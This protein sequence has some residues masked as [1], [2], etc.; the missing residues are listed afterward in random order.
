MGI[1]HYDDFEVNDRLSAGNASVPVHERSSKSIKR[2]NVTRSQSPVARKRRFERGFEAGTAHYFTGSEAMTSPIS[3]PQKRNIAGKAQPGRTIN[4]TSNRASVSQ[5]SQSGPLPK[6]PQYGQR[7]DQ[8]WPAGRFPPTCPKSMRSAGTSSASKC[9]SGLKNSIKAPYSNLGGSTAQAWSQA[10]GDPA[11]QNSKTTDSDGTTANSSALLPTSSTVSNSEFKRS[12]S[13]RKP[14]NGDEHL[15]WVP[16]LDC[17][18]RDHPWG[19]KS[20][21]A[22][23]EI[24]Q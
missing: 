11:C 20:E 23:E 8:G 16:C 18:D 2:A 21:G 7:T 24:V 10:N 5:E 15:P 4:N 13:C 19:C 9:S 17:G 22:R 3:P 14:L 12:H 1:L 6:T